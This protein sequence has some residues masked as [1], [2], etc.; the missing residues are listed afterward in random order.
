MNKV[1]TEELE[2]IKTQQDNL[3]TKLHSVGALETQKHGMLHE[4][5]LINKEIEE[6]KVE[7]EAKYGSI[8]INLEDGTY[9]A[10]EKEKE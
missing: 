6:F 8:N 1:T 2:K 4:L 5:A 7:L 9:S 3:N 10:I